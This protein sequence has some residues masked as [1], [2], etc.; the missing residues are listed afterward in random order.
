MI[1]YKY[2]ITTNDSLF[3][4]KSI[5]EEKCRVNN[6]VDEF[7]SNLEE[8]L[9]IYITKIEK[10][11]LTLS[12]SSSL[13]AERDIE[14]KIASLINI[15]GIKPQYSIDKEEISIKEFAKSISEGTKNG[16]ISDPDEVCQKNSVGDKRYCMIQK[17]LELSSHLKLIDM[18]GYVNGLQSTIF[19]TQQFQPETNFIF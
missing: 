14:I 11:R 17:D 13:D 10:S 15:L 1:Y 12:L 2:L 5:D 18:T 9:S 7:N 3:N 16:Y 4:R 8:E 6:I 19:H